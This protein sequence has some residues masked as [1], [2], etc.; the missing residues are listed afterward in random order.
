[1]KL[2]WTSLLLTS[3]ALI[4]FQLHAEIFVCKDNFNKIT[5][6]DEPCLDTTIRK[7]KNVPDAPLEDQIL[8]QQRIDKANALSLQRVQLAETE[9]QQ[10]EKVNREYQAIAIEKRKLELLE[11]QNLQ[12]QQTILPQWIVSGFGFGINQ[13]NPY[14]DGRGR[15]GMHQF[16]GHPAGYSSSGYNG[17]GIRRDG[18][19]KA[20]MPRS[21][22]G[23]HKSDN[24]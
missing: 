16:T 1:M 18:S 23:R 7:L 12:L 8:A 4:S 14:K 10:Q 5:Y 22:S 17:L 21:A 15:F 2:L 9:R 3:T 6:Q 20:H 13:F 24:K 19:Q 11:K